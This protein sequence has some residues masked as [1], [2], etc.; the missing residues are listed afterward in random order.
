VRERLSGD[1]IERLHRYT[2]AK[3]RKT[4]ETGLI[5]MLVEELNQTIISPCC[6]GNNRAVEPKQEWSIPTKERWRERTRPPLGTMLLNRLI[7]QDTYPIDIRPLQSR[8]V[9]SQEDY[10]KA[11]QEYAF[12]DRVL[13]DAIEEH[14]LIFLGTSFTDEPLC[15]KLE[16]YK[17]RL[18]ANKRKHFV[19]APEGN[20]DGERVA[21]LGLCW[22]KVETYEKI[23][24]ILQQV[25]CCR[26]EIAPELRTLTRE[27]PVAR[28]EKPEHYWRLLEY[29]P[30]NPQ[31]EKAMGARLEE[32]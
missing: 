24:E 27:V 29:G 30:R 18:V 16:R 7:L 14:S 1:C 11:Y 26:L 13:S 12:A 19:I 23:P 25:Y 4:E 6:L 2:D 32:E 20:M 15:Q 5:R 31:K 9:L 28:I 21:R 8:L 3:G 22:I 17:G 10:D